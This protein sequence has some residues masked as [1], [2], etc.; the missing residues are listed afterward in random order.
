MED[1]DSDRSVVPHHIAVNW[2]C[3]GKVL[4]RVWDAKTKIL[5]FLKIKDNKDYPQLQKSSD[6][7]FAVELFEQV[8]ELNNMLQ[9]KDTFAY[10]MYSQQ[11]R[12]IQREAKIVF[13]PVQ[14]EYHYTICLTLAT[15]VQPMMSTEKYTNMISALGNEFGCHSKNI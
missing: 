12:G 6:L 8:N 7:A 1:C 3:V 13:L 14:S 11:V 9:R 4:R 5:L 10:K 15:T 2:L